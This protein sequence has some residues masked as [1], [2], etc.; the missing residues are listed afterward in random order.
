MTNPS[1]KTYGWIYLWLMVL[2]VLEVGIVWIDWPKTAGMILLVGSALSKA[3]LIAL[4]FMHLKFDRPAVWLLPGI[5]MILAL[6]FVA[7][8]FPDIVFHLTLQM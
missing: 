7:A 8:L 1:S 6:L 2:T 3:A 5:P 4:Y